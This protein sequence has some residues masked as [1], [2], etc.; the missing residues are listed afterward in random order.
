MTAARLVK[1]LES[2]KARQ[3]KL[4]DEFRALSDEVEAHYENAD[5]AVEALESAADAVSRLL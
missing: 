2:L 4:R 5:E 3:A 1:K